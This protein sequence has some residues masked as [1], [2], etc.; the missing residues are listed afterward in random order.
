MARLARLV[1]VS[2]GVAVA[3][4]LLPA[5]VHIVDWTRDGP[6]RVAL[7]AP[8]RNLWLS[9]A[10]AAIAV[11][12]MGVRHRGET[13]TV[14]DT[15]INPL[16]LLWLW[17][18]PYLPWLPDRA[19]V[20]LALAGP[21]RWG[22]AAFALCGC[23]WTAIASIGAP[24]R[25]FALPGRR[26]LLIVSF[27]L[28]VT[29]GHRS[30]D[31]V[32]PDGVEPHYL[33]VTQSLL[34]DHDLAIENNHTRGDYHEYYARDLRPDFMR[35]GL[36]EVIY[37][38]HSPGLPALLVPAFAV[39]G[40]WGTVVMMCLFAALA[41]AAVF[42]LA[43]MLAG[44][45]VA[46]TTWA[47]VCLTVPFVPYSW[48]I[49][50]EMPGGLVVAWTALWLYAPL[51]VRARSW[52]W[53]G[54]ALAILPWL[55]TKFVILLA[56]MVVALFLRVWRN[57][58]A[59]VAL[60]TPVVVSLGLWL[61]SF[62]RLYGAFDPQVPYGDFPK[63]YVLVANIPRGV[64]GLLFDQKFGLLVYAP[65]YVIAITGCWMIL[66]R[67]DLRWFGLALLSTVVAFVASSARMYMWW[68]G[69]SAPARFLVPILPLLAPM[70][71][72]ALY[73]IGTSARR[74]AA[75]LLAVSLLVAVGGAAWPRRFMLFSPPHGRARL[76][77]ALQGASPL[78]FVLPTF[79]GED[80]IS[81]LALLGPRAIAGFLAFVVGVLAARTRRRLTGFQF[82]CAPLLTFALVS[83][84]A[85]GAPPKAGRRETV[86]RGRS[87]LIHAYDGARQRGFNYRRLET[88]AGRQ[89]LDLGTLRASRAANELA[90]DPQR[91]GGP[92]S[93]P[94]GR[95][96][97]RFWFTNET[98][99]RGTVF[100][101]V[102]D[103]LI[104][105]RNSEDVLMNPAA[106]TFDLPVD[107]AIWA[108][109]S[110][111]ALVQ[112]LQQVE[113]VAES[114]VPRRERPDIDVHAIEPIEGRPGAY[115]IYGDEETYPEGGV[116]WTRGTHA[117]R[118]WVSTGGAST[119]VLTLHVGPV[120]GAV[121]V[122]VD[123]QDRSVTLGRDETRQI[124]TPLPPGDRLVPVIV[125]A[126][127]QFRPSDH[128][129]SSTDRRWLGCQV[130]IGLR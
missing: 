76:V 122:L 32:G 82:V 80:T 83:A 2:T 9:L 50:P 106:L 4:W 111:P 22:V 127:E 74:A 12:A 104:I 37:S 38:I 55:H 96:S 97:A 115:M 59:A 7:L 60:V 94:A 13:T 105:A 73:Q 126:R 90:G 25:A 88:I 113:V 23:L 72:V 11:L 5:S 86:A 6:V 41:A 124:E 14:S 46:W 129:R 114:V 121:R 45:A 65:I 44:P 75:L 36:N 62:Y 91:V 70:I 125:E 66:R 107:A 128:E 1:C 31:G 71:A 21:L 52:I 63:L 109:V 17:T 119:I 123:G 49:F 130:R 40:Y 103:H 30:A 15:L 54:L 120:G 27:A 3:I 116:F 19:P 68:G 51:P 112:S 42:D 98:T 10:V 61:Y 78:S 118:V 56:A 85:A 20:L 69:S 8:L 64:L 92:F 58:R 95:Y 43:E 28:Y 81:E 89:L 77:E 24:S 26:T 117:G 87:E 39:A 53:R 99:R 100:V 35:R 18:I 16:M 93:L 67:S 79:T 47:A 57:P 48:L 102:G 29:F 33:V 101:T 108:G 84:V 110:D 34:R